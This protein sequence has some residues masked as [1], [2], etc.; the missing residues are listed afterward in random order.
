MKG[1]DQNT[2]T[3]PQHYRPFYA[4]LSFS[5]HRT[6]VQKPAPFRT[7]RLILINVL[8]PPSK[9]LQVSVVCIINNLSQTGVMYG[10]RLNPNTQET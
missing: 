6:S 9:L 5:C 7:P 3:I 8:T 2:I 1:G 10:T 4:F